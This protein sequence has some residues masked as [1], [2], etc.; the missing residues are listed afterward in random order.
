M[1]PERKRKKQEWARQ[2]IVKA[3]RELAAQGGAQALTVRQVA[4][5]AGIAPSVF[6]YYFEK[7]GRAHV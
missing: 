6:Y 2:T 1:K 5:R 4:E 3:A 7:I